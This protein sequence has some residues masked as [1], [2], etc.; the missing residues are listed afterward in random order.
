[1]TT[2]ITADTQFRTWC[3]AV[4][5]A[6]TAAAVVVGVVTATADRTAV[7]VLVTALWAAAA[8]ALVTVSWWMARPIMRGRSCPP[9]PTHVNGAAALAAMLL[10]LS[11]VAT[12]V[13]DITGEP[14]L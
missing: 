6:F 11:T 2:T 12:I 9:P 8:L 10:A 14:L 13:N 4:L 1:M 3:R 5:A 7:G